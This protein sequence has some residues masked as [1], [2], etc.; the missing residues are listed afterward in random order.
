MQSKPAKPTFIDLALQG[1]EMGREDF[2]AGWHR[3]VAMLNYRSV[4]DVGSGLGLSKTRIPNCTTHEVI[5]ISP[6][7]QVDIVAP[8]SFIPDKSYDLVTAFDVIEHVV[9]DVDF[10]A[11]LLRIARLAVF[12]TTPNY[13]ISKAA[14]GCHCREYTPSEFH[15]LV[16]NFSSNFTYYS[17]TGDGTTRQIHDSPQLFLKHNL[18]H[19]AVTIYPTTPY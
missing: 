12:I 1:G 2:Q 7:S 17:G 3:C 11:E 6:D 9:E 18:P 19:H 15:E 14:N 5:Q 10:L 4:L 8:L 13:N 16:H